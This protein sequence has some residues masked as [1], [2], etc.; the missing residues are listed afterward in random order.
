MGGTDYTFDH[1]HKMSNFSVSVYH[2]NNG[3]LKKRDPLSICL[4]TSYKDMNCSMAIITIRKYNPE[5]IASLLNH[6][7][8]KRRF[9]RNATRQFCIGTWKR[10]PVWKHN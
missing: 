8:S 7:D 9:Y 10:D 3:K 4:D 1:L 5:S 2:N 6:I